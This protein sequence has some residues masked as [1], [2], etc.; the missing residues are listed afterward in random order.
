VSARAASPPRR[1]LRLALALC[2][3]LLWAA[4]PSQAALAIDLRIAAVVNEDVISGQDLADRLQLVMVTSGVPD[5]EETRAR[6]APQV[7][8]GLIEERLQ[9]Q[10]AERLGIT[11]DDAEIEQALRNIAARNEM[12]P[13]MMRSFIIANDVSMDTLIAQLRAQIAW[14]KV[15]NRQIRPRV[16]VSVDQL[17]LAME[18]I[19]RA[20]G[21]PEYHLAEIVLP[22]DGPGQEEAVARDALRLVQTVREGADFATFAR[23][24]SVAASAEQGGDLG[25]VSA[26]GIPP[27]LLPTLERM[28]P[29]DVS[30]PIR[31]NVGY[32]IFL[33]NERRLAAA[34]DAVAR[35]I[36]V[37][38]AQVLFAADETTPDATLEQLRR[39]AA[40][41]RDRLVDCD[42]MASVA[43]EIAAPA[44]GRLGWLK[45]GDLPPQLARAVMGLEIEDVSPPL[46]GPAGI[47]LLMVCERREPNGV[48]TAASTDREE[49]ALRLENERIDRLARRYLRDL[50][51]QAFIEVRL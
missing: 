33:L 22:V 38:L 8:R 3:L 5:S 24:F 6:L 30:E 16:A 4:L 7:L 47:H 40:A 29:G 45:V 9:L 32:H 17:D 1:L 34:V 21:Q 18:E 20:R 44:S 11:V 49:L 39:E 25:W 51:S 27:E 31:S 41:L 46:E 15:V 48:A 37:E 2:G 42:A 36:E 50:R 10:E 12:T 23:Q 28:R 19:G 14:V 35:D 26:S 13:E 43:E